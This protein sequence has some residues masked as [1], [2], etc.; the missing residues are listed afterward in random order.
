MKIIGTFLWIIVGAVILWFFTLNLNESVT[1]HFFTQT[2]ENVNIIVVIFLTFFVG[3]ILGAVLVST[4][5]FKAKSETR[6]FKQERNKLLKELDGLRNL[7]IDEIPEP[8][9]KIGPPANI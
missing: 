6:R 3:V 4:Q 2:Y 5:V 9:T 8:D 7:S 1:V